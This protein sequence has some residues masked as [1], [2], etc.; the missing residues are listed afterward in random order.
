[1]GSPLPRR[2]CLSLMVFHAAVS[3]AEWPAPAEAENRV[4]VPAKGGRVSSLAL[5]EGATSTALDPGSDLGKRSAV[6]RAKEPLDRRLTA[7]MACQDCCSSG[8]TDCHNAYL[9]KMP[10]ICCGGSPNVTC[11]P[12]GS[13]CIQ[14]G[15]GCRIPPALSVAAKTP[16]ATKSPI[17]R[18]GAP[19]TNTSAGTK[20]SPS[21]YAPFVLGPL[22]TNISNITEMVSH[23]PSEVEAHPLKLV[24]GIVVLVALLVCCISVFC[25]REACDC[26]GGGRT[27]S[28]RSPH[29]GSRILPIE[30]SHHGQ[31]PGQFQEQFPGQFLGQYSP[32]PPQ[33]QSQYSVQYPSR[34]PGPYPGVF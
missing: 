21:E 34:F 8:G 11:C 2:A 18:T 10:G 20:S 32:G 27:R 17:A 16:I 22:S 28:L 30:G 24:L 14:N 5:Y 13:T 9:G 19:P 6:A 29:Y 23:L 31:F 4:A 26:I 33:Q 1:M 12:N 25:L 3:A 15:Q 7:S